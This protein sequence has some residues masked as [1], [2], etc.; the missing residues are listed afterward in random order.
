MARTWV[1]KLW[2]MLVYRLWL[3]ARTGPVYYTLLG[4]ILYITFGKFVYTS[5]IKNYWLGYNKKSKF[6]MIG[7]Y[8]SYGCFLQSC[9]LCNQLLQKSGL[10]HA[11]YRQNYSTC[12]SFV[13]VVFLFCF[14]AVNEGQGH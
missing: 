7:I 14:M 11:T 10:L 6:Q 9:P 5:Y 8:H 4:F 12:S 1:S 13:V 2:N 3:V